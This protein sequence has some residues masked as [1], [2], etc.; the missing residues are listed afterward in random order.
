M[1]PPLTPAEVSALEA[2]H[3]LLSAADPAV[4][5][6][7]VEVGEAALSSLSCPAK[8]VCACLLTAF[9]GTE[10]RIP[11]F[12]LDMLNLAALPGG[13][14]HVRLEAEIPKKRGLVGGVASVRE[15]RRRKT[16][17]LYAEGDR[18]R[19][20]WPEWLDDLPWGDLGYGDIA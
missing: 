4:R 9:T 5:A 18:L 17:F 10:H 3:T 11:A 13:V 15:N 20:F 19:T 2:L 1:S 14:A 16:V 7:G 8:I 6:Q 12:T